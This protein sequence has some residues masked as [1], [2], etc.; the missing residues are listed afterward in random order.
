MEILA[1]A[2]GVV[3]YARLEVHFLKL[4]TWLLGIDALNE[5]LIWLSSDVYH[6]RN[7]L[8]N[9]FS[10]LDMSFFFYLFYSINDKGNARKIIVGVFACLYVFSLVELFMKG[11]MVFHVNSLRCYNVSM[12][13]LCCY[14]FYLLFGKDYFEIS[15]DPIFYLLFGVFIYQSLLF[16]N[17]TTISFSKYWKLANARKYFKMMQ[18]INNVCYYSLICVSFIISYYN[19]RRALARTSYPK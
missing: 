1:F 10:F 17:F 5:T 16:V 18:N 4:F 9:V 15:T 13:L 2:I 19:R 8:Y 3:L 7:L 11:W 12:I 14:F 6:F